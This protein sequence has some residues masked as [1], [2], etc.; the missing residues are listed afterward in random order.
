MMPQRE[1][2]EPVYKQAGSTYGGYEG[3]QADAHQ[4]FET[5]Y[6]Q[7]LQEER[8]AKVYAPVHDN[9]NVLRLAALAIAMVTLIALAVICLV[10]VGGTGGWISFCAA[11]LAMLVIAGVAIDKMQ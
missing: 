6:Q 3:N 5:S 10:L 9:K 11:S 7:P 1:A 8:A 2:S 4:L